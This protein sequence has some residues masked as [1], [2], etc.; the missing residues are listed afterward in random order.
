LPS[1][2]N[3]TI[4]GHIGKDAIKN[5][6][7]NGV[8]YVKFSVAVTDRKK[9]SQ[10]DHWHDHTTWLNV[11]FWGKIAESVLPY[12]KKGKL[13]YVQGA[14]RQEEYQ[15]DQG[16]SR[17]SLEVT[18]ATVLSLTKDNTETAPKPTENFEDADKPP[19]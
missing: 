14:L 5:S 12:L 6:T 13:V 10:S 11:T 1:T 9:S 4:V 7:S 2:C 15:D 18:A 16:Y 8:T 17:K 19:F 3:V